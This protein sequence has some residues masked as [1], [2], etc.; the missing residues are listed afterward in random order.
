MKKECQFFRDKLLDYSIGELEPD[1]S[2]KVKEHIEICT[3]C[4]KIVDDY[5]KISSITVD[6]LKVDFSEDIWEMERKEIIKRITQKIDIV[7]E[8]KNI[9]KILFT[10][11]RVLTAVFATILLVFCITVGGVQYKKNKELN[12]EKIII[13][14]IGL[15]ENIELLERFDFYKKIAEKGVDL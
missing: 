11:N 10:T 1:I 8:I 5:K 2:E 13:E 14:N 15:F 9:L 12:K 3:D 4:W 6:I 7:K